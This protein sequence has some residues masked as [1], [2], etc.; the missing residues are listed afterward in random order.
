MEY[1]VAGF[2]GALGLCALWRLG[3]SIWRQVVYREGLVLQCAVCWGE[4]VGR[5]V[6]APP[7]EEPCEEGE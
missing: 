4:E 1:F 6:G 3:R 5:C 2:V 7:C